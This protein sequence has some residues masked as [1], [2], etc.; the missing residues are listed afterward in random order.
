MCWVDATLG[1][2]IILDEQQLGT[3]GITSF[4]TTSWVTT[5]HELQ[6]FMLQSFMNCN[7]SCCN[8]SWTICYYSWIWKKKIFVASSPT[9]GP[10]KILSR[11]YF[12]NSF[13]FLAPYYCLSP[14]TKSFAK[15][16]SCEFMIMSN[17]T[18]FTTIILILGSWG[19]WL[20]W[21]WWHFQITINLQLTLVNHHVVEN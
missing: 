19:F 6:P 14:K 4:K 13:S 2:N 16:H 5:I 9:I 15:I 18:T 1:Q 8:Y 17:S 10:N 11:I 21:A 12:E 7:H 3:K 20:F